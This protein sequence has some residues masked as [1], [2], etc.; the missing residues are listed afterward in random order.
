MATCAPRADRPRADSSPSP[1]DEPVTRNTRPDRS[2]PSRT[3]STVE[4]RSNLFT[5]TLFRRTGGS[6]L[7]RDT[8][9]SRVGRRRARRNRASR[10]FVARGPDREPHAGGLVAVG[11]GKLHTPGGVHPHTAREDNPLPDHGRAGTD[12]QS[13]RRRE[14]CRTAELQHGVV[15]GRRPPPARRADRRA[16]PARTSRSG[17]RH[18]RIPPAPSVRVAADGRG[19]AER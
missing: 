7:H 14:V 5:R 1:L 4:S 6:G 19:R 2:R 9:D 8:A 16:Q 17:S 12:P 13:M 3:S 10:S 15:G 11:G 18:S